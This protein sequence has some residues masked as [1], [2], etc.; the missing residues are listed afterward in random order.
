MA[1]HSCK[2]APVKKVVVAK[3]TPKKKKT[4]EE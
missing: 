2:P 4:T 3:P 1:S